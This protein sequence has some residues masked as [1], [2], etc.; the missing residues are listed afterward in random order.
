[1]SL[2]LLLSVVGGLSLWVSFPGHSLWL[3]A[4][5]GVALWA[6]AAR[7][8]GAGRGAA[9]LGVGALAFMMPTLSWSGVYV[10]VVPWLGLAG[11]SSAYFLLLGALLGGVRVRDRSFPLLVGAGWVSVE[12]ARSTVPYGGFP[13]ARLAFSQADAPFGRVASLLG[14]PGV[15]FAVAAVGGALAVAVGRVARAGSF[16]D[17]VRSVAMPLAV[18]AAVTVVPLAVRV[19]TDGPTSRFVA[20]Q[21]DVPQAGLDFNA[22]RR[23]VLDAHAA[24]T[25]QAAQQLREAG[26]PPPD[27]VVWPENASDIDP[28]RRPDAAAVIRD[29]VG[30]ID[31]PV[32]VGAVLD[33]PLDH[34]S[35]SSL[36]YEP[37]RADP[38]QRYDK[39]HPAPFAEYIPQR[40]FWRLFSDKV[41]LVRKDFAAGSDVG[42]FRVPRAGGAPDITAGANICFEVAYDD[43]VRDG[44]RDG[45]NVIMVQTNNATFGLTD[46]SVQQLAVSRIRAIEHG[47]SVVH[48][49]NVGVSA[50]I[51]PDGVPH[52]TTSL[53]EPAVLADALPLRSETTLATRLGDVPALLAAAATAVFAGRGAWPWLRRRAMRPGAGGPAV[54]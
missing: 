11:I 34:L 27:L 43:L 26:V 39:R 15:T 3:A 44:V 1:M 6:L 53:F 13:W 47:R 10:G 7:D 20:I 30:A 25:R 36:L 46:E 38:T 17:K 8:V 9:L 5:L 19:P 24:V 54:D 31:A 21:G 48:I 42:V 32:V 41:D 28:L 16:G 50:L 12:L 45:A 23:A 29:A 14:A 35:N 51:T 22:Q 49:S 52:L 40:S 37:G 4:P 18:A 2:R 33:E